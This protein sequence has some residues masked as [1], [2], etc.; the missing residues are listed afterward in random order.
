MKR[1]Q[2]LLIDDEAGHRMMVRVVLEDQGW[3]VQEAPSGE[4]ALEILERSQFPVILLD[5]RLPGMSGLEVL[6]Q[7]N[8]KGSSGVVVMLTAYGSVGDAV[9]AMKMGAFDYLTKPTDNEEMLTVVGKALAYSQLLQENQVLRKKLEANADEDLLIGDSQSIRYV[10]ELIDQAGPSEATI[11]IR[12]QSGT[13]KELVAKA[14]HRASA[15]SHGP[16]VKVNCAALPADLL[17]SELFGYVKGAF[18]G[19]HRD[20]PGRFQLAKGGTLF[21]DEIGDLP[22]NLQP[23]LLRALQEN[24]IEPL[25]G[26]KPVSTDARIVA[27]T[28][29]DLKEAVDTGTFRQDLFFRLN[30]LEINLPPL[31]DHLEDLPLL[32]GHLLAKLSRKNKKKIPHVTPSFLEAL[33]GYPWPG[34]VRELENVLERALILNRS[35]RLNIDALPPQFFSNREISQISESHSSSGAILER[36][37]KQAIL[38]ALHRYQGHREQTA[39]ALGIS[40]RN[41]Q[42]KLKRFGLTK[43]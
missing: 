24:E 22:L 28:N 11:L 16:L 23:K 25:G 1:K 43:K 3:V 27:A 20:K 30:V 5:M 36:T 9:E 35:E 18:T 41:L 37:E 14:L 15:R 6:K 7:M 42:Y 38:N 33:T 4:K 40:R 39:E 2:L 32:V 17:E 19:A 8:Q 21:L 34:N 13:G 26:V 12:G 10:R 31:I 29:K